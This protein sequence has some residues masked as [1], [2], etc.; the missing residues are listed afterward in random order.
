[1][2]NDEAST[3]TITA[4]GFA[5]RTA[6]TACCMP[7]AMPSTTRVHPSHPVSAGGHTPRS[8]ANDAVVIGSLSGV[9]W[10]TTPAY[11]PA[12]APAKD[13]TA[14]GYPGSANDCSS[15]VGVP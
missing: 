8:P 13:A 2:T 15:H 1:M 11:R 14:A 7:A 3:C 6:A 5:D 12:N 9:T 4:S 10:S